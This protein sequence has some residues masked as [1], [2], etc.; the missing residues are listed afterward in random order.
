VGLPEARDGCRQVFGE[1]KARAKKQR[2]DQEAILPRR[3]MALDGWF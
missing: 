1:G 3:Q 2:L